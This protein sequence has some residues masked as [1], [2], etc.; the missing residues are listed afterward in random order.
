MSLENIKRNITF[1]GADDNDVTEVI[2][3]TGAHDVERADIN[4]RV[5]YTVSYK[6]GPGGGGGD[7]MTSELDKEIAEGITEAVKKKL[8]EFGI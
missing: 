2:L 6:G 5:S 3:N 4:S 1:R 8:S 7:A